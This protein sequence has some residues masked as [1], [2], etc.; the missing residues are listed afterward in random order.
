MFFVAGK[1]Y[2]GV[3][4]TRADEGAELLV[5]LENQDGSETLPEECLTVQGDVVSLFFEWM[6]HR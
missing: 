1:P 2:Q 3:V 5:S 4:W 6:G